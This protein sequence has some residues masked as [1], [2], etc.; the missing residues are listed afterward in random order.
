MTIIQSELSS[1]FPDRI[2]PEQKEIPA[3]PEI[4][5]TLSSRFFYSVSELG[6]YSF[7]SVPGPYGRV[8]GVII[9]GSGYVA[10][11]FLA[12]AESLSLLVLGLG[13]DLVHQAT[14][15]RFSAV[16]SLALRAYS[17]A[18]E[19]AGIGALEVTLLVKKAFS[20]YHSF[21]MLAAHFVHY[22]SYP[23]LKLADRI[24]HGYLEGGVKH[25]IE[26][27]PLLEILYRLREDF[28]LEVSE[29]EFKARLNE[30]SLLVF[31][32]L[33]A[34]HRTVFPKNIFTIF[35]EENRDGFRKCLRDFIDY[36][37]EPVQQIPDD[38]LDCGYD[39]EYQ[40]KLC[41]YIK[42]AFKEIY[43][44]EELLRYIDG[45][46][47]AFEG[48][49]N[50][51]FIPLA[52][53]A[54]LYELEANQIDCPYTEKMLERYSLLESCRK[55][56][57]TVGNRADLVKNLLTGDSQDDLVKMIGELA[58]ELHQGQILTRV[59]F[60]IATRERSDTKLFDKACQEALKELQEDV[61]Q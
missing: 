43:Q 37:F 22:Y 49:Y 34:E 13:I 59:T 48:F 5:K 29:A 2:G 18:I 20:E 16:N 10:G 61:P 56:I 53:L 57:A 28:K 4:P 35:D 32:H 15:S 3:F 19:A 38:E 44:T 51:I 54:Q 39:R 27:G 30:R 31:F 40:R 11:T 46:K 1:I 55:K 26:K 21:N 7:Q 45:G 60:N 33:H 50:Q 24:E 52:K 47:E 17:M 36:L 9:I 23:L 25:F 14:Y 8:F 42:T 58:G 12:V 41:L 6:T